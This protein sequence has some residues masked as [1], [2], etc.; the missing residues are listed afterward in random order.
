MST[1]SP[2]GK[3]KAKRDCKCIATANKVLAANGQELDVVYNFATGQSRAQIVTARIG[4]GGRKPKTI[5]AAS[6]CPFC[7]RNYAEPKP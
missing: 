3:P 2:K 6:F 5:L 1:V 7:G 4:G